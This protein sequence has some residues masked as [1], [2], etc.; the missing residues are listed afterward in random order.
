MVPIMVEQMLRDLLEYHH[1]TVMTVAAV[2]SVGQNTVTIN[3]NCLPADT[4]LFATGTEKK[5]L[6]LE[7]EL[8]DTHMEVFTVGDYANPSNIY[9][10]VH[11]AYEIARNL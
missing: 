11:S 5:A 7:R 3:G 2:E 10:A 4:V 9:S 6:P 8:R 1:V